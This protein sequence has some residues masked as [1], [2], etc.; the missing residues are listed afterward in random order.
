M[1]GY[2]KG[3]S[4]IELPDED[5][6]ILQNHCYMPEAFTHQNVWSE[7]ANIGYP[8]VIE[9]EK[10]NIRKLRKEQVELIRFSRKNRL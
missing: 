2:H 5:N 3:I 8:G 7:G 10:W 4:L 1:Y 6:L 9:G